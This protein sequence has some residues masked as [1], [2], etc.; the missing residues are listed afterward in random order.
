MLLGSGYPAPVVASSVGVTESYISQL[1]S[2]DWFSAQVQEL[3]FLNLKK[4]TELDDAY[5][6]LEEKLLKKLDK[7]VPLLIKPMDVT[8]V[9]QTVN[10]AKRRGAGSS[11]V[12]HITQN[13][14]QLS[15]P[16]A[17]LQKFIKNT[18][19]Q[20]VEVQDGTGQQNSLVTTSSGSLERL[21]R[22]VREA[23][24]LS[25]SIRGSILSQHSEDRQDKTISPEVLEQLANAKTLIKG[26]NESGRTK[27]ALTAE[28]L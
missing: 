27:A 16:E 12:G 8:R 9:L 19:N 17:L 2:L 24:E 21:S 4:H 15:L 13:I 5:D 28:D 7:L 18:N 26:L 22:E 1:M 3:K 20:I 11:E 14:V 23:D 6:D 10:S 25:E